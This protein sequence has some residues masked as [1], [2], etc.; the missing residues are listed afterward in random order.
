MSKTGEASTSIKTLRSEAV[1]GTPGVE[2]ARRIQSLFPDYI[3]RTQVLGILNC[4]PDS[5]S[6]GGR[7]FS[8]KDALVRIM[9]LAESGADGIDIGAES[10]RPGADP[11]SPRTEWQR[12]EAWL[13]TAV[14]RVA[15][16][17]AE[18]KPVLSPVLSID[19]RNASTAEKALACG[20][21]MVNDI[22]GGLHDPEMYP[23]I[24]EKGCPYVLMHMRGEPKTM[25]SLTDYGEDFLSVLI[26]ELQERKQQALESGVKRHQILLD[27]GIGFAKTAQQNVLILSHF[28][29]LHALGYPLFVGPSRKSFLRQSLSEFP[30]QSFTE[31]ILDIN[32]LGAITCAILKGAQWVRIHNIKDLLPGI[33]LADRLSHSSGREILR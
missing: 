7:F 3:E 22:S 24:A 26:D 25:K 33:R 5:F 11:V 16:I 13:P 9:D 14:E 18:H 10:T 27:P 19:T 21:H 2:P 17:S 1:V 23:L 6:D 28:E 31:D 8:A 4:T 30:N 12:L 15:Q 32:T 29:R 20:V